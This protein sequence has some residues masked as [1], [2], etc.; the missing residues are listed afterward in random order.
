MLMGPKEEEEEEEEEDPETHLVKCSH[1]GTAAHSSLLIYVFSKQV[2]S[3]R[4]LC[5]IQGL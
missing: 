3:L 2:Y 4:I 5:C 1:S